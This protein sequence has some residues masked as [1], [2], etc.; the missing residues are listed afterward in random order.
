MNTPTLTQEKR[1]M[2]LWARQTLSSLSVQE[3]KELGLRMKEALC[4]HLLWSKANSLFCYYGIQREPDTVPILQTALEQGKRLFLPRCIPNRPGE[5]QLVRVHSLAQVCR[6]ANGL[7]EPV[8]EELVAPEEIDLA[9]IPCLAAS[10]D[11]QRLGHGGGYYDRFLCA[12]RGI[13]VILCPQMAV[14]PTVP[15]GKTDQA[16]EYLLTENG[17]RSACRN[18]QTSRRFAEER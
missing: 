10:S 13:S 5:M 11:G 4:T 18:E 6:N 7:W 17:L 16:A 2:R 14:V 8:G 3:R 12:F 15:V 9:L 1:E